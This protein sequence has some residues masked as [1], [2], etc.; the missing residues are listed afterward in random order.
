MNL[1][2]ESGEVWEAP[3]DLLDK[4]YTYYRRVDV[5]NEI[6]KMALWLEGNPDRRKTERGML[7]FFV[8]WMTHANMPRRPQISSVPTC[9]YCTRKST[10][11]IRGASYCPDHAPAPEL[12]LT[13]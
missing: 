3:R 12:A 13:A 2:T 7:R 9:V 1:L 8:R 6:L 11:R 4:F 5:D 10:V